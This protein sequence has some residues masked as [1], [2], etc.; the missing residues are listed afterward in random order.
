MRSGRILS[1]LRSM[2]DGLRSNNRR[3]WWTSFALVTLLCG[4]WAFANPPLAGP[5]EPSHVL[6]AVAIDRGQLTGRS[7][8]PA[9]REQFKHDRLDYLLVRVPAFYAATRPACFARVG[10]RTA[11][12][13]QFT[14]STREVDGAT[15][16]ARHPPAY[17][18]IVGVAS[19]YRVSG[20]GGAVPHAAH[21]SRDHRRADRHHD[22]RA[23]T[24][25]GTE[26]PR[27]RPR[28]RDHPDGPVREQHREPEW[29][30]D[31]GR[32]RR[33]GLWPAGGVACPRAASIDG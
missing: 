17:Y 21:H 11:E 25:G 31:R 27:R 5:D 16:V 20:Y 30:R 22:H 15:Y 2:V 26:A 10:S 28:P 12:C 33:L 14:N 9:F 7:L 13:L 1:S 29:S 8:T 3:V 24:S 4:L 32:D 6:R 18:A 19:R 23:P